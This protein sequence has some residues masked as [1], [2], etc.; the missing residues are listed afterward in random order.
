MSQTRWCAFFLTYPF[1]FFLHFSIL[2]LLSP[3][4]SNPRNCKQKHWL[5]S[6]WNNGNGGERVHAGCTEI[7]GGQ[8]GLT[9]NPGLKPL[10][11]ENCGARVHA[12]LCGR[13]L[14]ADDPTRSCSQSLAK[15]SKQTLGANRRNLRNSGSTQESRLQFDFKQHESDGDPLEMQQVGFGWSLMSIKRSTTSVCS[16]RI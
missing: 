4:T 15:G 2:P 8:R 9:L 7:F 13:W 12:R 16:R 14:G 1:S 10:N 3:S 5:R 11:R 6:S